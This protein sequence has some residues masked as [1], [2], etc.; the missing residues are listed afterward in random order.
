MRIGEVLALTTDNIDD[1]YIHVKISLTKDANSKVVMGNT[2]KTYNSVRDIPIIP[3]VK[4]IVQEALSQ[5]VPN[6]HNLV[7]FDGANKSL[8][9]PYEI[10]SYLKRIAKKYNITEKIHNHMLRHTYAT[11]CIESGMTAVVL[12]K[13]LGHKDI[14][15]TL[16]TYTSIF[17]K[18]EDTQD[19]RFIKYLMTENL[20]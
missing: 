2:A 4:D 17:A 10:N 1:N 6:P 3:V 13:K 7:F 12:A 9:A 5:S 14:S 15:I 11:R 18:F 16:N 20:M 19:D 8:I